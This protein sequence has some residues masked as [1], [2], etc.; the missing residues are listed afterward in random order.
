MIVFFILLQ[1]LPAKEFIVYETNDK[2]KMGKMD[3]TSEKDSIGYHVIYRWERILEVVFDSLDMSTLYVKK[4]VDDKVELEISKA[5]D[6]KVYF[7]GKRHTYKDVGAVYDRHAI[8]FALRG[9]KYSKDFKKTIRFHVPEFMIINAEIK[10]IG[11]EI[12]SGPI[13]DIMCWKVEMKPKVLFFSWKFYFWIEKDYPHRFIRYEDSSGK[14]SILL[15]E[16]EEA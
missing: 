11:E 1:L 15:I 13:G 8:E 2:G 16:Y 3:I 6:F 4:I 14:N 7:K 5:K 9:F 10:V 12:V